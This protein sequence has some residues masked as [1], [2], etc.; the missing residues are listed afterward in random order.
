VAIKVKSLEHHDFYIRYRLHTENVKN[1][2]ASL[3]EYLLGI[4]NFIPKELFVHPEN[5]GCSGMR[6]PI[7]IKVQEFHNH[8]IIDL[9]IKSREHIKFKSR[10][11]NLQQWFLLN[12]PQAIVAELP[13][14]MDEKESKEHLNLCYPLTGHIDLLRYDDSKIEIW[15]YKPNA[16]REKWALTQVY[17]YG[18]LLSLRARIPIETMVCGYFDESIAYAFCP[19]DLTPVSLS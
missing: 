18:L 10:H 7:A 12:D 9:A 19:K 2:P 15:D 13:V 6:V 11:E 5:P 3:Q 8:P 4:F 14:W 16:K 17:F 1:V